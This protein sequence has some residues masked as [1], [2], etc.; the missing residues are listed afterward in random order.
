MLEQL[1]LLSST[2]TIIIKSW[3]FR[4]VS[5]LFRTW[6]SV[7]AC[8]IAIGPFHVYGLLEVCGIP[9]KKWL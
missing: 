3:A 7:R 9:G 5:A 8:S 1:I 6:G 2:E 4:P